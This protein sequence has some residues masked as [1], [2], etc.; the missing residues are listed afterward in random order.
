MNSSATRLALL[1]YYDTNGLLFPF[2]ATDHNILGSSGLLE[3][4][5][6]AVE[7]ARGVLRLAHPEG[8]EV[9]QVTKH[10]D[11][12]GGAP[13]R[14]R[15][16]R[17]QPLR[18]SGVEWHWGR[19]RPLTPGP[20]LRSRQAASNQ[21]WEQTLDR[22]SQCWRQRRL[23]LKKS[24]RRKFLDEKG[25]FFHSTTARQKKIAKACFSKTSF[26][27]SIGSVARKHSIEMRRQ[28]CKY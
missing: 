15:G 13:H 21:R 1:P 4:V 7:A 20:A 19:Q 11:P 22:S 5:V 17:H 28:I 3:D 12:H 26:E 10:R 9:P 6:V 18:R 14:G 24:L 8:L 23:K 27:N 25:R 2:A 16:R